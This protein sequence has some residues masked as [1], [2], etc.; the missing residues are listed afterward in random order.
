VT[1]RQF[2]NGFSSDLVPSLCPCDY[3]FYS[4][5]SDASA[6]LPLKYFYTLDLIGFIDNTETQHVTTV[7][8]SLANAW[9]K[10]FPTSA[11]L[12]LSSK[13]EQRIGSLGTLV[14]RVYYVISVDGQQLSYLYQAPAIDLI[15]SEIRLFMSDMRVYPEKSSIAKAQLQSVY[16]GA[17]PLSPENRV[18][19]ESNIKLG[20]DRLNLM[21]NNYL[22]KTVNVL[23]AELYNT[24]RK[25]NVSRVYYSVNTFCWQLNFH[26][27]NYQFAKNLKV[28]FGRTNGLSVRVGR[29]VHNGRAGGAEPVPLRLHDSLALLGPHRA[30]W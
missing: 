23:Y 4:V 12:Q 16:V 24:P 2:L 11:N 30:S 28:L 29:L 5:R 3:K 14:T 17:Y 1:G 7:Y 21:T 18:L 20:I 6:P 10:K 9:L 25:L 26:R 8:A 15:E 19:L 13:F 27:L 22:G